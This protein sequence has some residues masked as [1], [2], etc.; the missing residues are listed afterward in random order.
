MKIMN[1]YASKDM[2][3]RGLRR[4]ALFAGSALLQGERSQHRRG[5][6]PHRQQSLRAV[7]RKRDCREVGTAAQGR[8]GSEPI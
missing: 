4:I 7:R 5:D 2:T 8:L 3:L 6:G 1:V